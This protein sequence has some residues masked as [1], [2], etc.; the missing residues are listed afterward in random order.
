MT[1]TNSLN[2]RTFLSTGASLLA[3]GASFMLLPGA[4]AAAGGTGADGHGAGS[5]PH[6]S[7]VQGGHH[8]EDEMTKCAQL[9]HDCQALC[10][11]TIRHCLKLGGRHAAPEHMGLLVDCAELCETTAHYLLRESPLHARLCALCAE[12]CRQCADNCVQVGGDDAIL[13]PCAELCRRCAA[14]CEHMGSKV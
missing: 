10:L 11:Q 12:V 6:A 1:P 2:R 5:E 14:S 9:C 7:R 3:T 4:Y 13:K 8:S